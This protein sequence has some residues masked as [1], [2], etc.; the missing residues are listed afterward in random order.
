MSRDYT[1]PLETEWTVGDPAI[2]PDG[3]DRR[4]LDLWGRHGLTELAGI[5]LMAEL[6]AA[7]IAMVAP[8]LRVC[9]QAARCLHG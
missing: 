7:E 3:A 1:L 6:K 5:A 2:L 4:P 8:N 9:R